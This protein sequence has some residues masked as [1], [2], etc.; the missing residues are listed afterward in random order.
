MAIAL[1]ARKSVERENSISCETQIEYCKAMLKPDE[2]KEKIVSF[3]DN[4][5]SGGNT[6][7]KGFQDMM[8]QIEKGTVSKVIVYRLDRISRSL[9]DFVRILDTLKLHGVQ[10]VSSQESFDTSSP[11]GEM[12]VKI[13]MVFAEFERQ[14]I[15]TRV[16][17]AYQHR[18]EL[19][20]YMGGRRPYG[21]NLAETE[22]HGI[23]TKMLCPIEEEIEQVRYIFENYAVSGMSLRRLM[24]DLI[25]NHI[26]PTTG[27]WSSAKISSILQNPIYVHAD[28]DIYEYFS[29][30][31]ANIVSAVSE[32]DGIHGVQLYGK[33]KHTA[34][35]FSD[36]KIVVMRHEG[37]V[38]SDLWLQCQRRLAGN[39]QIGKSMSNQTSWLGGKLVCK[40]CGRTM[41][42]TKGGLLADGSRTRY[43]SCSGK[44]NN[45]I[46]KGVRVT[47]YADS[48]EQMAYEL[49][50]EK[51]LTLKDGR[52]RIN[53][54]NAAKINAV[55]NRLSEI[56]VAQERLVER[57]LADTVGNDLQALL[58]E[59]AKKLADEKRELLLQIECMETE[60]SEVIQVINLSK[61]W[62]KAC[63]EERRAV[64]NLLIN[65]IYIDPNGTTEVVWNI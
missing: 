27:A 63:F 16:T 29:K 8:R 10:F 48:L 50:S 21:F 38:S 59:R 5:Y 11:Y 40:S 3:V 6:D 19:G 42:V 31:N 58:N 23:K 20:F 53:H 28:N 44:I 45:R 61:K 62:A 43:F 14:S 65:K 64:C 52:T 35:D 54:D 55:K 60:E 13:L 57:M 15:I 41:T 46:C 17:Q 56:K 26:L 4:G 2:R 32:F 47:L 49:I 12:I 25:Q 18:S 39:K 51:L 34:E 30:R 7:R 1:Y 22:I 24:D 36:L 37:V 9:S 33:T